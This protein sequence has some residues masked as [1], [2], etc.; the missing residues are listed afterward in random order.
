MSYTSRKFLSHGII[1]VGLALLVA[2]VAGAQGARRVDPASAAVFEHWTSERRAAAIPRDFVVD[3]RGYGYLRLPNGAL[4]PHGHNIAAQASGDAAT[5]AAAGS[6]TT[7]PSISGMDPAAGATIGANYTFKATVT[8]ASGV[9]SVSFKV[10]SGAS[11]PVQSFSATKGANDL[12]SVS[13]Q[14]FTDGSWTWQV[15]AKDSGARSGN[16]ASSP[17]LAF[18][19]NTGSG[20]GGGGGGTITNAQWT[21]DLAI[22]H[23]T[24]RLYFEMPRNAKR[25]GPW[26]GYVCSG[27]VADDGFTGRSLILTAAHCVYDD[28]NK[29]FARNVMFIP[30]QT[31]TTGTGTDRNC[32]NDPMGCWAPAF[33]VVDTRYTATTFP[34]NNAWD[35]AFYVVSDTGAHTPGFVAS[36]DVLGVAA[37]SLAL[38]FD[39]PQHDTGDSTDFTHA[40]GYSYSDD[41][42]FMYCAEDMTTINGTI[43]WWL[44]SCGLSGGASG[45]PW[46]Q[47]MTGST[48]KIRSVNSWG[49]TTGP[50]MA[51]PKFFGSSALCVFDAAKGTFFSDVATSA[52]DAGVA[53]HC[54]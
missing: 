50:G 4:V 46:L 54:P 16:I 41:P 7:P 29:A 8:D 22:Q 19:V 30:D 45:G 20:G 31:D 33:G 42:N 43:N 3:A 15:V 38:S 32:S 24:G 25:G 47:P 17:W 36:S 26:N 13:L 5:R 9:K 28:A 44:P 23:A 12:W 51:G 53:Y 49:Y 1:G 21:G 11:G 37:G 39:A 34:N 52:G 35:Y 2:G 14:G 27:T 18:T 10:Q 6:D 40:L 48:S